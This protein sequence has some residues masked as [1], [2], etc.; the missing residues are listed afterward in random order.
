MCCANSY[1]SS[2]RTYGRGESWWY[3]WDMVSAHM[4]RDP[5]LFEIENLQWIFS[6]RICAVSSKSKFN[7]VLV[8]SVSVLNTTCDWS[9]MVTLKAYRENRSC[10]WPPGPVIT[11][12]KKTV[13][14]WK[15]KIQ[16]KLHHESYPKPPNISSIIKIWKLIPVTLSC[17]LARMN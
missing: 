14:G 8:Y 9:Q 4:Y 6:I 1:L 12:D 13:E 7:T 17:E 10:I 5:K 16:W 2:R 15:A 3:N 11:F